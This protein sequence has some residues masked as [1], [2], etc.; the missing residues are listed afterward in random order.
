MHLFY[1]H[2]P[3]SGNSP[4]VGVSQQIILSVRDVIPDCDTYSPLSL[5]TTCL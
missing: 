3:T 5:K 1:I 2:V 4:N